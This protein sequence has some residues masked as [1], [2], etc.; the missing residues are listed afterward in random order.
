VPAAFT[1]TTGKDHWEVLLRARAIENQAWVLAPAQWGRHGLKRQT[2]G[3]ALIC[4][5]WGLV[6]A[7]ASDGSG[8]AVADWN[9]SLTTRIRSELPAL[10][11]RR[12]S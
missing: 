6:V 8:L 12:V 5:P 2:Y 11:H 3:H 7:R 9:D 1:L 10:K 4:D